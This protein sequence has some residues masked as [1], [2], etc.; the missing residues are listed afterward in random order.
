MKLASLERRP[1]EAG[2]TV[3]EFII[4]ISRLAVVLLPATK[5]MSAAMAV[6]RN[7]RSRVVATNLASQTI[8]ALRGNATDSIRRGRLVLQQSHQP[9]R[10]RLQQGVHLRHPLGL[11]DAALFPEPD[12]SAWRKLSVA[13]LKP[14]FY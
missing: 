7:T 2:F 4:A 11:P 3:L 13:E 10:Q 9:Q 1:G 8:E 12:A 6:S 14:A 5:L